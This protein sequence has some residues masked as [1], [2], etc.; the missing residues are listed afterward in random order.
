MNVM[1]DN[2]ASKLSVEIVF[3]SKFQTYFN[4]EKPPIIISRNNTK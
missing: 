4:R 1:M 2:A 3:R